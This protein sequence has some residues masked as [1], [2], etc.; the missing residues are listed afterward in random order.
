RRLVYQVEQPREAVAQ[1]EAAPAAVADV[2]HPAQLGVELRRVVERGVV[3][4]QLVAG[5]RLEAAFSHR[6]LCRVSGAPAPRRA[7]R[8]GIEN[9]GIELRA[10][11]RVG[12]RAR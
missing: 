8:A 10:R 7:P 5:R 11:G 1:I 4:V 12:P 9:P 6:A 2:E 3:P